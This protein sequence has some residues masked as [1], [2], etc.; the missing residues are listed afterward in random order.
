MSDECWC[1]TTNYMLGYPSTSTVQY[2]KHSI[3]ATSCTDRCYYTGQC[4]LT[5]MANKT[6]STDA[7]YSGGGTIF[8]GGATYEC[9]PAGQHTDSSEPPTWAFES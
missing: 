2:A 5:C 6:C 9:L 7:G 4:G 3:N 1:K 8:G